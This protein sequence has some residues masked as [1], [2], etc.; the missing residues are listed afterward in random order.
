MD[1]N[2]N[3]ERVAR[4]VVE[5]LK[6]EKLIE[7]TD[8]K[9][10]DQFLGLKRRIDNS[11]QRWHGGAQITVSKTAPFNPVDGTLWLDIS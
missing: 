11:D 3:Q 8:L 6:E 7:I 5:I 1:T 4:R 9:N 10:G 2:L